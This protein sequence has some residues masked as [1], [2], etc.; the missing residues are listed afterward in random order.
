MS[1][2]EIKALVSHLSPTEQEELRQYIDVLQSNE[3]VLDP[4]PEEVWLEID[5]REKAYR[6]G[7]IASYPAAEVLS[8]LRSKISQ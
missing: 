2:K 3:T 1:L 7:S 6:K 5:R 4:L 8:Q